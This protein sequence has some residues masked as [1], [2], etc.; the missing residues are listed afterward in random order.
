MALTF[1]DPIAVDF[2]SQGWIDQICLWKS[3]PADRS[4]VCNCYRV[5]GGNCILRMSSRIFM[6]LVLEA[7]SFCSSA[8]PPYPPRDSPML[9]SAHEVQSP[10]G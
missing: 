2:L 9:Y 6:L 7:F 5:R 8:F 3:W 1:G 10:A 4:A